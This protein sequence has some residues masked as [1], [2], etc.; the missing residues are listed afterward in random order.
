MQPDIDQPMH[1]GTALAVHSFCRNL[2][3]GVTLPGEEALTVAVEIFLPPVVAPAPLVFFCQP[4]GAMTRGYYNLHVEGDSSF[5]FAWALA[6]RGF[7]VV[8]M[9]HLGVGDSSRP[10][11][12]YA[13]TP[14]LI[15]AANAAAVATLLAEL[16]AGTCTGQLPP[17]PALRAIG[18][19]HSMGGLLTVLQQAHYRSYA[20]IAP[21]GFSTRGLVEHLNDAE[22][23]FVGDPAGARRHIEQLGR[24]RY[25]A[26]YY[27]LTSNPQS[28]AIFYGAER[29]AADALKRVRAALLPAP[30]LFSMIPGSSAPEAAQIDV[31]VFLGVGDRDICGPSHELPA[32]FPASNEVVLLVLPETGHSHFL[33]PTRALLFERIAAWA[34]T[35]TG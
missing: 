25:A 34:R 18:V 28:R 16:R 8:T 23:R 29:S 26:P 19:G 13:V 27:E 3:A 1:A 21:L 12:G 24:E 35:V 4:G 6:R 7:I 2:P 11:D 32:S 9:D 33:F 5:S 30:S 17:L 10:R 14:D 31:P 20:A 22:R 15:T